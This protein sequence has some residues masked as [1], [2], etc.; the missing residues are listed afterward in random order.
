M[1]FYRVWAMVIRYLL[2]WF[3]NLN[4]FLDDALWPILDIILW[5]MTSIWIQENQD[6]I[7]ES[8]F[9]LLTCLVLWYVVQ[10][11]NDA[12]SMNT[13]EELWERNLI[14]L[15]STP[16]TILEWMTAMIILSFLRISYT[17]LVCIVTVWLLYALNIFAIGWM[18]I[19]F[20]FSLLLSGL[21][22]GF[23]TTGFVMCWGRKALYFSWTI[24][25]LFSPFSSVYYPLDILPKWAQCIGQMLPMTYAFQGLRTALVTQEFPVQNFTISLILNGIYLVLSMIF[26]VFMFERSRVKGFASLQ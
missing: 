4:N 18:L 12:V 14:N 19:P 10:R 6:T 5:G 26:F 8:V 16:L 21:F 1:R 13:L 7:P 2:T 15:F 3:H 25:W 22:I 17:L 20:L 9:I 11:A 23:F 24:S